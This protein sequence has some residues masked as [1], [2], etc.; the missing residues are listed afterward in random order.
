MKW[1]LRDEE[2]ASERETTHLEAHFEQTVQP[3]WASQSSDEMLGSQSTNSKLLTR[4]RT[5]MA[6]RGKE[7]VG[8]VSE[9]RRDGGADADLVHWRSCWK[10]SRQS[11]DGDI[12]RRAVARPRKREKES[13]QPSPRA[14]VRTRT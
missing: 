5:T 14:A 9:R 10:E 1:L 3:R 12:D 13:R 6:F 4:W 8:L 2:G 11:N 7:R